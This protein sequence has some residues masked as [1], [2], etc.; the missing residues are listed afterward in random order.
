M[1]SNRPPPRLMDLPV[2]QLTAQLE[3][4]RDS[5]VDFEARIDLQPFGGRRESARNLLHYLVFRR[6]DLRKEQARL[7]HWGLS[8]LGRSEG[9]VLYNLNAVLNW[10]EQTPEGL[11]GGREVPNGLDPETGRRTLARNARTLFGPGRSGRRVRIMV[12]LP[13]E[14]ATD[15]GLV[16]DLMARGMD[17]ARINCAHNGPAEWLQMIGHL[18]RAE[19][20]LGR[21]CRV[22]IDLAGPKIRTGPLRPGP[23]VV[24]VR[25]KRDALGHLTSPGSVWLVPLRETKVA[26]PGGPT[27][28]VP[29]GWLDR[30]RRGESVELRDARNARR[31]LR[32]VQHSEGDWRAEVRKTTYF[33]SGTRLLGTSVNG[34]E[35]ATNIGP[36]PPIEARIR[37]EV[38]DRLLLTVRP[39]PGEPARHDARGRTVTPAHV[40]C[41]LPE[42]LR[43][44]RRGESVWLDDGRIGGVVRVANAE[45]VELEVT[46]TPSGGTWL[47]ADKG[48]N[49]PDTD[50]PLSPLQPKDL[51]DLR[52]VVRHA[53]L[54]GYSFVHTASDL[55]TLRTE[56][57]RLGRPRMGVVLKVETRRA[58]DELPGILLAGLRQ[59][60][61]GVMIARGD[62]AV[63]VGYE[64]LAEVQ[65]EILWL[66]E[67]AHV[68]AIWATQVLE[69]LAKGGLPSRAEVTDAAMGERAECVMLNKGPHIVEAIRALDSILRRMQ[70]HQ[71]KKTAMLRHLTVVDRFFAAQAAARPRSARPPRSGSTDGRHERRLVLRR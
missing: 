48:I 39:D 32:L 47:A 5:L 29:S 42:A 22:E 2:A 13:T 44:V 70:P 56:L 38:G 49:L 3:S 6:H 31:T 24:K 30:R 18:H 21:R 57:A 28:P 4:V 60:P 66:C 1:P 36:L 64:R 69:G 65:E 51:E 41:T 59:P 58:F 9:H 45:R 8:S 7:A 15:Y 14:A 37:V 43:F 40:A 20:A 62:L 35:D 16:R 52:F 54:V 27:L 11:T 55:E 63:E 25:P 33:T 12:T 50:L 71:A 67:A 17:C 46:H 26:A 53:D 68:P 10:L 61:V 19:R 23:A 34:S